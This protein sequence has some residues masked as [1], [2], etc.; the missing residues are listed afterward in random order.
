MLLDLPEVFQDIGYYEGL[1]LILWIISIS[2]LFAGGIIFLWKV[3]KSR[4]KTAKMIYLGY[5]IFG[6]CFAITRIWFIIAVI[7]A[8]ACTDCYDLYTSLGYIFGIIGI[9]F[10]LAVVETYMIPQTKRVFTIITIGAFIIVLITLF[11]PTSRYFALT[12]IY[13]LLPF[14][15]G[16]IIL[17]YIYIIIKS[18]G[19]VRKRAIWLFVG[20][21]FIAIGYMMDSEAFV[22]AVPGFPLEISPLLMIIGTLTFIIT[23]VAYE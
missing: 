5:A 17:L 3:T 21:V 1:S 22:G 16:A 6:I 4:L 18:T 14:S 2:L 12:M 20:L 8:D 15:V 7:E 13:I 11:S 19:S 10:W 9:L 23:Q